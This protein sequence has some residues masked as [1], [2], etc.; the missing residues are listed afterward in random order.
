MPPP[1]PRQCKGILVNWTLSCP[2]D[3]ASA[4]QCANVCSSGVVQ[5]PCA[6]CDPGLWAPVCALDGS[7]VPNP[8]LAKAST[9]AGCLPAC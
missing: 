7:V 1:L 4:G 3:P 2:Q 6:A 5:D 8:C 9:P